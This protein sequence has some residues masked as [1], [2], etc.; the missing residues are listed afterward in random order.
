MEGERSHWHLG[1]EGVER[2]WWVF[3]RMRNPENMV[4]EVCKWLLGHLRGNLVGQQ[5]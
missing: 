4:E 5:R 2:R 1:W 3:L